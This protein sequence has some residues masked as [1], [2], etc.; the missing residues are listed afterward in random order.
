MVV[1]DPEF[2]GYNKESKRICKKCER[3]L[4]KRNKTGYCF[5]C[6]LEKRRKK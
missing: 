4:N 5:D 3:V 2:K 6:L 1:I